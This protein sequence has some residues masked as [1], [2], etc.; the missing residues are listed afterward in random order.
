M[1]VPPSIRKRERTQ[2]W[3]VRDGKNNAG[4]KFRNRQARFRHWYS[5]TRGKTTIVFTLLYA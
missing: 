1:P 2:N 3:L 4:L 5:I